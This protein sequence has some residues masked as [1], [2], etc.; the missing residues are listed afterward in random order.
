MTVMTSQL[1]EGGGSELSR[2]SPLWESLHPFVEGM[3]SWG[4]SV[5]S[6]MHPLCRWTRPLT[7]VGVSRETQVWV[8]VQA[9]HCVVYCVPRNWAHAYLTGLCDDGE[10]HASKTETSLLQSLP[11]VHVA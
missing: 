6:S 8:Q 4:S 1:L 3:R 10:L 9:H 5:A 7:S 2:M 11:R